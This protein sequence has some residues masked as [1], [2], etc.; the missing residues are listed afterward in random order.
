L[1]ATAAEDDRVEVDDGVE[2]SS[3]SAPLPPPRR[4]IGGQ[5]H[6]AKVPR[7]SPSLRWWL[8]ATMLAVAAGG[9]A[10]ALSAG[11]NKK[12]GQLP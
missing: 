1:A 9:A 8:A 4:Q 10:M 7:L 6:A 11:G 5:R 2:S 3:L 12:G